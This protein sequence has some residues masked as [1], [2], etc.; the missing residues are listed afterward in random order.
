MLKTN[1]F[2]DC[3]GDASGPTDSGDGAVEDELL[4]E[5]TDNPGTTRGTK[6][7]VLQMMLFPFWVNRGS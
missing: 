1:C 6:L 7:S 3:S 5:L 2:Q 4:S